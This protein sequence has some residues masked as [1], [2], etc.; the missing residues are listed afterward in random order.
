MSANKLLQAAAGNAGEE[1]VYVEDVFSTYLYEGNGSTQTIT[2]GIDL[3]GE[4][5]LVW[6][7][8]R[9]DT[10]QHHFYDTERG[11][12]KRIHSNST[13]AEA[14][15][16]DAL[17]AFNSNGFTLGANSQVNDSGQDTCSWSFR[18]QAGFFDIVKYT[19]TGTSAPTGIG[20]SLFTTSG[21]FTVPSNVTKMAVL[22]VGGGGAGGWDAG[23]SS[24]SNV[25]GAGGGG[26]GALAWANIDCSAGQTFTVTVG[27]GGNGVYTGDGGDGGNSSVVRDS[28]SLN[29]CT[30]NGG[31]GGGRSSQHGGSGSG[32]SGGTRSHGTH[33]DILTTGGGNG[34]SGGSGSSSYEAPDYYYMLGAGGGAGGYSGNGGSGASGGGGTGSNGSG[35][36]A[37]GGSTTTAGAAYGGGGVSQYGETASGYGV[38]SNGGV[39]GSRGEDGGSSG[40][41]NHGGGGPASGGA[42]GSGYVRIVYTTDTS[43]TP[44]YPTTLVYDYTSAH[45]ISHNLEC[46]PGWILV[47]RLGSGAG[48]W[49]VFHTGADANQPEDKYLYLNTT[50]AAVDGAVWKDFEPTSEKFQIGNYTF[51]NESGVEYIAYLWAD[52]SDSDSQI[53]GDDSDESIIKCGSYTGNGNTDGPDINLGFE[54]Q[55]VMIKRTDGGTNDWIMMDIMRGMPMDSGGAYLRANLSND[56][57]STAY[58]QP[59]ATGFKL[60]NTG[61][62]QVNTSGGT[63]IYIAIRRPMKTPEAATEVFDTNNYVGDSVANRALTSGFVTDLNFFKGEIGN[64]P[65][66]FDRLRGSGKKLQSNNT[67]A[68]S[69]RDICS[70]DVQDGIYMPNAYGENNYNHPSY[71]DAY[72]YINYQFKRATGFFDVVAYTGTG[73]TGTQ[74]HNLGVTPELMIFKRRPDAVAWL[75]YSS[76]TT[77][78][79]FLELNDTAAA[80]TD[81]NFLNG[82]PTSTL[83]NTASNT[84]QSTK[85]YIAY[86]FATLDGVS[87]VGSYTGTG[88]DINVDCGFSAGARFV[89]V[90]RTDSTGDWYY[91]DTDRGIVA[92][93][94]SYL[95]F[96]DT[97]GENTSNDYIDPLSSGFT[98]TSSAPA[99]L[100]A[101]GGTYIFLAIA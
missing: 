72:G 4:G 64:A 68:E 65:S 11:A 33:A 29:I 62:T 36:A 24:S 85:A 5:G 12:T 53:F 50:G 35:G 77:A 51:I 10:G 101:S 31:S 25:T 99:A 42:G 46:K 28:D 69:D 55:W 45:E 97:D 96:N 15:Q 37:A 56:E 98:I 58:I 26:G 74:S 16:S 8:E 39:G 48:N 30:A 88:S 95:I 54:A 18:K 57:A 34:G 87:K 83:I 3:D 7:K 40:G 93:N 13:A 90:K 49:A 23:G 9:D 38:A 2:N 21:T 89:M 17:T 44:A 32:G 60:R 27:S 84:N 78:S 73:G 76:P 14:T 59:T 100:N 43:N 1:S 91:W 81:A 52:G 86:L 63:Y 22:C 82:A 66:W 41:G 20:Q 61:S 6:I 92:G 71:T 47:K 67:D 70:F 19:G 75:V 94:D 80:Q 79:K